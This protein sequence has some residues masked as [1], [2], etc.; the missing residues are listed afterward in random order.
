M[1]YTDSVQWA[2]SLFSEANL[3]DKRRTKRL[4]QIA[5]NSAS[6][7]GK[8]LVKTC[9]NSAEI[10]ASYRF[11]RNEA[12]D[13]KDVEQAGF[14][15]TAKHAE[16]FGEMLAIEDTTSLNYSHASVRDELGHITASKKARG[17]QAHSV[18]L[19]ATDE[20]QI[21]GLIEQHRWSRDINSYGQSNKL[22]NKTPYEEKESF[23]WERASR[24]MSERLSEKAMSRV[25][26]VCDRE[27]DI[28]EYINYKLE[29]NQR[30]IVRSSKSRHIEEAADKLHNFGH[31]LQS[32]GERELLVA[33][34]G[35]RKA[36]KAKMEV[37]FSSVHIKAPANKPG[38]SIA[39]SY[40]LCKEVEG[41]A[42]WHLLTSEPITNN[43][44]AQMVVDHYETR[45]LIEDYHKAW[46]S[47]GTQVEDLRMQKASNLEKMTVIKAFVAV[48][49]MQLRLYGNKNSPRSKDN[50]EAL[51]SPTAW[52]LLWLKREEKPLP[53]KPPTI[54]W[55]YINIG[56]LAGWYD[57]KRTGIVGWKTLWEGWI[58]LE[59]ILDGYFIAKSLEHKL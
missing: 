6:K 15:V 31:R 10:E 3:G 57:S 56:K 5:A 54:E 2:R 45:W 20:K 24:H 34:K 38:D 32:A 53:K 12:I 36:R 39:L 46:K 21:I 33:Q 26:S 51:L 40:V 29:H 14:A 16:Q 1:F 22:A 23:K 17:I 4:V 7:L 50:C 37:S 58:L 59:S 13:S 11:M 52:K 28:I 19:Y 43:E 8:S 41:E 48:R 49:V 25:I 35:G 42:C 9:N 18:L 55:A 27:A 44:Q 47:S 30:F